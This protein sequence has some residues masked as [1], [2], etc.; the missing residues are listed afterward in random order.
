MDELIY[1]HRTGLSGRPAGEVEKLGDNLDDPGELAL[2]DGQTTA[3]IFREKIRWQV[4]AQDFQVARDRVERGA[5]LVGDFGHD[6]SRKGQPLG[7]A[8]TPL[9]PEEQLVQALDLLVAPVKLRSCLL[10]LGLKFIVEPVDPDQHVI[11]MARQH[12]KFVGAPHPDRGRGIS[13][14]DASNSVHELPNRPVHDQPDCERHQEP[15]HYDRGG[16][17]DKGPRPDPRRHAVGPIKGEL[18]GDRTGHRS[19]QIDGGHD[20]PVSPPILLDKARDGP[21]LA[22]LVAIFSAE[23]QPG[24]LV[25]A[26]NHLGLVGVEGKDIELQDILPGRQDLSDLAME[27]GTALELPTPSD[28]GGNLPGKRDRP[29]PQV[30]FDPSPRN[31]EVQRGEAERDNDEEESAEEDEL[32]SDAELHCP[33]GPRIRRGGTSGDRS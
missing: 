22:D 27:E 2:D 18:G 4:L 30:L 14:P 11:E 5:D 16:G 25:T 26:G 19:L 1:V 28:R 7:V 20:L 32:M 33:A 9:H 24:R 6:P 8:Q 3:E 29:V 13:V 31:G 21:A 15:H 12:P 17:E 23:R 10:H